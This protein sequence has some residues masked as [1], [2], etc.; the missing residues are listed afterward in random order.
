[1][2]ACAHQLDLK[3][4][5]YGS[6]CTEQR[7]KMIKQ[8]ESRA[9]WVFKSFRERQVSLAECTCLPGGNLQKIICSIITS[10]SCYCKTK[11]VTPFVSKK[12]ILTYSPIMANGENL[13]LKISSTHNRHKHT[14]VWKQGCRAQLYQIWVVLF[15]P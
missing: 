5:A 8:T 11:C 2:Y 3:N 14:T 1:M 6:L 4:A 7:M 9:N 15:W 12:Y 10:T 13:V